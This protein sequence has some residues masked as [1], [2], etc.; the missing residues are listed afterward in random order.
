MRQAI[1]VHVGALK[2]A[3]GIGM[4]TPKTAQQVSVMFYENATTTYGDVGGFFVRG[5]H[6]ARMLIF[7]PNRT[8]SS[9]E[10]CLNL[11]TGT[12]PTRCVATSLYRGPVLVADATPR[13]RRYPSIRPTILSGL[14]RCTCLQILRSSTSS[15]ANCLT[16]LSVFFF[17]PYSF[18]T[19][20]TEY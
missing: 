17:T 20:A 2:G 18:C 16:E 10:A 19:H 12:R 5:S 3:L 7:W 9:W 14:Q 15:F 11:A 8:S 6:A 1:A 4:S 13:S